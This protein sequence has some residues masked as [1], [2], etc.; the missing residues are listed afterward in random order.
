[1]KTLILLVANLGLLAPHSLG[2]GAVETN[3]TLKAK[4]PYPAVWPNG[5]G[6]DSVPS[7]G[8]ARQDPICTLGRRTH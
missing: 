2:Q 1:M 3:T 5:P 7:S 6:R 4:V 8:G